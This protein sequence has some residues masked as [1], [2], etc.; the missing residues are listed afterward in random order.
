MLS[1]VPGVFLAKLKKFACLPQTSRSFIRSSQFAVFTLLLPLD[2]VKSHNP[3]WRGR[4]RLLIN[5]GAQGPAHDHEVVRSFAA[6]SAV[7]RRIAAS[8]GLSIDDEVIIIRE[9]DSILLGRS[10]AHASFL[11][12]SF[13]PAC[14]LSW[15]NRFAGDRVCLSMHRQVFLSDPC[16]W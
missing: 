7:A 16:G 5:G 10:N 8:H 11:S 4:G 1:R 14:F 15:K 2:K 6:G 3:T 13:N 12:R 9:R